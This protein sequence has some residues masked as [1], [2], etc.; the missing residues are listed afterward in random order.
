MKIRPS[1][2]ELIES[3]GPIHRKVAQFLSLKPDL[4]DPRSLDVLMAVT[5]QAPS[6]SWES[7]NDI[8]SRELG[9]DGI[10]RFERI[11][12]VPK[13]SRYATQTHRGWL[14]SGAEVAIKIARPITPKAIAREL[15]S[16]RDLIESS[17]VRDQDTLRELHDEFSAWLLDEFDLGR[18]FDNLHR[19]RQ[20]AGDCGENKEAFPRPYRA[21]SSPRVLTLERL[22]GPL[23]SELMTSKANED[24]ANDLGKCIVRAMLRCAVYNRGLFVDRLMVLSDGRIAFDGFTL[25]GELDESER[26]R[27][28]HFLFALYKG[29]L[30]GVSRSLM[31]NLTPREEA[32]VEAF[33]RAWLSAARDTPGLADMNHANGNGYAPSISYRWLISLLRV[34]REHDMWLPARTAA[35]YRTLLILE[36]AMWRLN[37]E[38]EPAV[39]IQEILAEETER[40]TLR[41]LE[42]GNLRNGLVT[43]VRLLHDSPADLHNVIGQIADGSFR[44][45]TYVMEASNV[46][47]ARYRSARL[48][49]TAILCVCVAVLLTI[50]GRLNVH[51]LSLDWPLSVLLIFL[52]V[53]T[54]LQWLKLR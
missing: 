29:D 2:R 5:D 9:S 27:Q 52:L 36:P 12:Q 13:V 32:D 16:A 23:I 18:E 50:P 33:R 24:V 19:L 41:L 45:R 20:E 17:G 35:L 6:L 3:G 39:V 11:E 14:A 8:L 4:V 31:S 46:L 40:E 37:R 21:L 30:D 1:L 53:S 44:L 25:V 28:M 26:R 43:L 7:V 15:S 54:G 48:I 49:T 34:A 22:D 38:G 10:S 51:G 42:P 47:R